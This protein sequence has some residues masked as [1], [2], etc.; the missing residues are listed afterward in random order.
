MQCQICSRY[1]H[2]AQRCFYRFDRDYDGQSGFSLARCTSGRGRFGQFREESPWAPL[3]SSY[4]VSYS[5]PNFGDERE[6]SEAGLHIGYGPY[7]HRQVRRDAGHGLGRGFERNMECNFGPQFGRVAKPGFER[8]IGR[9]YYVGQ[10]QFQ[11]TAEV[12]RTP[13]LSHKFGPNNSN[14]LHNAQANV[15]HGWIKNSC[16]V[17]V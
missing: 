3:R 1:G 7:D 12:H 17:S 4:G 8:Q 16:Y 2:V 13:I 9:G 14:G 5:N 11:P 15:D 10:Q 6:W